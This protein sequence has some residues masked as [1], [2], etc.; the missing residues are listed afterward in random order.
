L[1]NKEAN[2]FINFDLIIYDVL[3]TCGSYY[4]T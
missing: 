4:Y 1:L 2:F 3:V